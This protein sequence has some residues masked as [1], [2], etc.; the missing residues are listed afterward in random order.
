MVKIIF[1]ISCHGFD[2][3]LAISMTN[4]AGEPFGKSWILGYGSGTTS[5]GSGLRWN[6]VRDCDVWEAVRH[7]VPFLSFSLAEIEDQNS[8]LIVKQWKCRY[9]GETKYGDDISRKRKKGL[10]YNRFWVS[11]LLQK[12]FLNEKFIFYYIYIYTRA[13]PM[14]QIN[15][16]DLIYYIQRRRFEKIIQ[17]RFNRRKCNK[18]STF[19]S[20]FRMVIFLEADIL[21][22]N[23]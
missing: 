13:F 19:S 18:K 16:H 9:I 1:A 17:F 22:L 11:G 7:F 3:V 4:L 2:S 20:I 6:G 21:V 8:K 15:L 5:L 23:C 10:E 12:P 14:W